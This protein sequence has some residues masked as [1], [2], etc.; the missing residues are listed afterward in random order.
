MIAQGEVR[1]PGDAGWEQ[2]PS[3]RPTALYQGPK[4]PWEPASPF[5]AQW[6]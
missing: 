5:A 3:S 2:M 4:P 6:N 1:A